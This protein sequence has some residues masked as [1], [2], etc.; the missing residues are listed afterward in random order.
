MNASTQS[1]M[2]HPQKLFD[3]LASNA[4]PKQDA[5]DHPIQEVLNLCHAL[6]SLAQRSL[7]AVVSFEANS[8]MH[9]KSSLRLF[10]LQPLKSLV[11]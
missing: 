4:R 2:S 6:V 3:E 11:V 5:D 7:Y 1:R 8:F 10:H 9:G